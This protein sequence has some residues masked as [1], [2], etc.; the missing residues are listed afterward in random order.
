[1]LSKISKQLQESPLIIFCMFG[2]SMLSAVVTLVLGWADFY[3]DFL[4][5][6]LSIPVWLVF[7]VIIASLFVW[8]L[9][10]KPSSN[11]PKEYEVIEGKQFGVQRVKLDGRAFKRCS[12]SASELIFE[13]KM[14]FNLESNSFE[15]PR[16]T[17][18]EGAATTLA[19]LTTMYKDPSFKPLVEQTLNNIKIG[20]MP[21]AV[22]VNPK[23]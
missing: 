20:K 3:K 10:K 16:F 1:M 12:F 4:S 18:S 21:E 23:A 15:S 2:L 17:F 13:G 22:P 9:L 6:T 11:T 7:L 19:V 14:G 5:K 8:L